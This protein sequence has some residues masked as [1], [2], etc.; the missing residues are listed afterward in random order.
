VHL[1]AFVRGE[2]FAH[3]HAT[4]ERVE[5]VGIDAFVFELAPDFSFK[6]RVVVTGFRLHGEIDTCD[7]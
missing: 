4:L 3:F 2:R 6:G 7:D 5:N 1:K